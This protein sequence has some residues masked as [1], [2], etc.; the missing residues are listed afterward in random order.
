MPDQLIAVPGDAV[1]RLQCLGGGAQAIERRDHGV[2]VGHGDRQTAQAEHPHGVDRGD[3]VTGGDLE[4]HVG[5]VQ[6]GRA[7]RGV[8]QGG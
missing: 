2:L 8:D 3:G 7:E 4:R 5:P 1:D 6:P